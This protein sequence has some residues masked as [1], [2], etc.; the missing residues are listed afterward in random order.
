M[1]A[2]ST[3]C[4]LMTSFEPEGQRCDVNASEEA[5]ICLPGFKCT[6]VSGTP[7]CMRSADAGK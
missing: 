1:M 6:V 4:T 7:R 5:D 3:G 2:L